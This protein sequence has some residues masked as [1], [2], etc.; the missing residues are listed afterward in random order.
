MAVVFKLN[1]ILE[2]QVVSEITSLSMVSPNSLSPEEKIHLS[3]LQ[4]KLN[5]IYRRKAEG[6]FVRSRVKWLEQ[7]ERNSSYFFNLERQRGKQNTIHHLNVNGICFAGASCKEN[8]QDRGER[9][10]DNFLSCVHCPLEGLA[11]CKAQ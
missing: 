11:V 4:C 10:T 1:R 8:I 5:A 7:G 6:A 9:G 2:E 3:V